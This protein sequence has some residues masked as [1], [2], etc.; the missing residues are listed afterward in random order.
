MN[1]CKRFFGHW[2]TVRRHRCEVRKLC[3]QC[4]LRWRGLVHDLSKYS[5]TEFWNGVKFF[6]GTNSPHHGERAKYGYSKAWLHHKGHNKH[7]AEYWQ[8]IGP[9]GHTKCV[10]MPIEYFVEMVCDR[11]AACKIYRGQNFTRSDP[12]NYYLSHINENQFSDKTRELLY[13]A[14]VRYERFPE[15]LFIDWLSGLIDSG[16]D[17]YKYI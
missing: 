10:D 9:D 17:A 1:F 5:P 12:K 13:I 11:I 6:T 3:V 14:L 8:D 4:G 2:R 7:H 16:D 15:P